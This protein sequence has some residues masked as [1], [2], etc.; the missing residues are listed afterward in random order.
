MTAVVRS[1]TPDEYVVWQPRHE[2]EYAENM[3]DFGGV[4]PEAAR[5]K[6]KQDFERL[7]AE[8]LDTAGHSF[9]IVDDDGAPAGSLWVAERDDEQGTFLFVYDVNVDEARRGRG[10]GR[11]A[12]QFA[13]EEAKRRNIPRVLLNVFGGNDVARSLYRSLGYDEMA[14]W[15]VKRV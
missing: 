9:Y 2:R 8:G 11:A 4:D 12:M 6:A 14:V 1:M 15:M 13:E 7:L 3:I 10:L 5:V